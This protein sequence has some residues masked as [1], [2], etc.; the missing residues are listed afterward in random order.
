MRFLRIPT[1]RTDDDTGLPG[2]IID[3]LPAETPRMEAPRLEIPVYQPT[4]EDERAEQERRR[5][6]PGSTVIIIDL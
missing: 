2:W 1:E 6:P 3:G 5:T 4:V